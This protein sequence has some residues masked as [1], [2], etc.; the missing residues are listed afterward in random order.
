MSKNSI[1]TAIVALALTGAMPALAA[2][3]SGTVTDTGGKAVAGIKVMAQDFNGAPLTSALTSATGEY[4]LSV[5]ADANYRFAIDPGALGFKKGEP[6]GAF[7]PQAGLTVNWV[8]SSSAEPLAYAR[9]AAAQVAVDDPPA[10]V[11]PLIPEPVALA[12]GAAGIVAGGTIGGVAAAG[13]FG[14]TTV[15]SASK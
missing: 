5:A 2:N 3:V 4:I 1:A 12:I 11:P 9:Q 6:V 14:G 7:V 10:I 13:G 15:V 8:V